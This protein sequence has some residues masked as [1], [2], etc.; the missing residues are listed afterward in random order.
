MSALLPN[1][2]RRLTS[3]NAAAEYAGV[4]TKT[5]RRRISDGTIH[6]YKL[7]SRTIRV[8]LHE[9]DAAFRAIPTAGDPDAT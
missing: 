7:G 6:G 5:I 4:S 3:I 9:L 8:D 1:T 2:E